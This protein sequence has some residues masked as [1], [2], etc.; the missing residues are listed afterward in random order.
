MLGLDGQLALVILGAGW[1]FMCFYALLGEGPYSFIATYQ[2]ANR[3]SP[4]LGGLLVAG[5]LGLLV[6]ACATLLL[7]LFNYNSNFN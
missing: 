4:H 6:G 3:I 2:W 7:L 5:W 1:G